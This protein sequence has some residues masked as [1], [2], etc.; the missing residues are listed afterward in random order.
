MRRTN[1]NSK[2]EYCRSGYDVFDK[3]R[4]ASADEGGGLPVVLVIVRRPRDTVIDISWSRS[5]L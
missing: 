1:T 2:G 5:S 4:L 3:V